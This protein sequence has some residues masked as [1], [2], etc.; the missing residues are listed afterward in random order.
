MELKSDLRQQGKSLRGSMGAARRESESRML[1]ERLIESPLFGEA[2]CLLTY[3][4]LPAEP[5]TMRL[6][7]KALAVG[8]PVAAPV[9]RDRAMHF[10]LFDDLSRLV[11]GPMG[12]LQPSG[13]NEPPLT[14]KTLCV[15]PGYWFD[16]QGYRIGYG[17]GYY[18]RFLS[19]FPGQSAGLCFS[20]FLAESLPRGPWDSPVKYIILPDGITPAEKALPQNPPDPSTT[21]KG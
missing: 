1:F 13:G 7:E 5:D 18:D 20:G 4:S 21:R 11:P 6:V 19:G 14:R 8:L 16:R 17:G 15:V 9:I 2:D 12:I 10:L 3:I